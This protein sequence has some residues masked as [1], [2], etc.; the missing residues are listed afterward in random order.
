MKSIPLSFFVHHLFSG[1]TATLTRIQ[2]LSLANF[3]PHPSSLISL[4][5]T[6]LRSESGKLCSMATV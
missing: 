2:D 3:V 6:S 4:T 1:S 5:L